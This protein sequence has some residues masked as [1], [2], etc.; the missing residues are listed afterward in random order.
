MATD[1]ISKVPSSQVP[2]WVQGELFLDVLKE[3]VKGFLKIKSFDAKSGSAAGEN[4]ATVML[5]VSIQVELEG[6]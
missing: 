1:S 5:R 3:T 4:Y 6:N 2:D